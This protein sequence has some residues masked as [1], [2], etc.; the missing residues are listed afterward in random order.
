MKMRQNNNN[1]NKVNKNK[2]K[3]PVPD[4][5]TTLKRVRHN[6]I[7]YRSVVSVYIEPNILCGNIKHTKYIR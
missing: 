5:S 1:N 2:Q 7:W 3:K 4:N 6:D